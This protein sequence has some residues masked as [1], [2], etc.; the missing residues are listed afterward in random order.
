MFVWF[1]DGFRVQKDDILPDWILVQD[2]LIQEFCVIEVV[3]E[4]I[5]ENFRV[6]DK[7]MNSEEDIQLFL[8]T[9]CPF[10]QNR[11]VQCHAKKLD[12]SQCKLKTCRQY[13]YC[14]IHLKSK[15]K[16]QVKDSTIPGAGKGLFY[17]GREPFPNKKKITDY[18]SRR[19]DTEQV[20]PE[21]RYVIQVS[22]NQFLDGEDPLNFV[23]RYINDPRNSDNRANT[24]F[25]KGQHIVD[26]ENRKTIPM[27]STRVIQPN[28]ELFVSY[29]KSYRL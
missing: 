17:V 19:V 5:F 13:P 22:K 28:S 20:N 8:Q 26:K 4:W 6:N 2:G 14:W 23:G 24:R 18:S 15:D 12:G 10:E 25:G 29:G 16:L 9:V 1:Y 3:C 11:C 27:Y 21:A 7:R